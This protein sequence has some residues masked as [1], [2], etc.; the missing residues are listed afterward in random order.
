MVMIRNVTHGVGV[1][2]IGVWGG[3][4]V[5][6]IEPFS[7]LRDG[8]CGGVPISMAT[9]LQNRSLRRSVHRRYPGVIP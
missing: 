8:R 3:V 6:R 5:C 1:K 7:G 9:W 4:V 2:L